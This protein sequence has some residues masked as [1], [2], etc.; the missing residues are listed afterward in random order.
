MI[1]MPTSRGTQE[2]SDSIVVSISFESR[3]SFAYR[4]P[5]G[6]P[7]PERRRPPRPIFVHTNM[8]EQQ[9]KLLLECMERPSDDMRHVGHS[10]W[11]KCDVR[12]SSLLVGDRRPFGPL[13]GPSWSINLLDKSRQF[14]RDLRAGTDSVLLHRCVTPKVESVVCCRDDRCCLAILDVPRSLKCH[15]NRSPDRSRVHALCNENTRGRSSKTHLAR[16]REDARP[17]PLQ[18]DTP[19]RKDFAA[20]CSCFDFRRGSI[21]LSFSRILPDTTQ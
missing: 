5:C 1:S 3:E 13:H 15:E 9:G 7:E 6:A 14:S 20:G 21:V 12:I 10:S 19:Q 16:E 18:A 2:N 8:E 4:S 11:S 17:S